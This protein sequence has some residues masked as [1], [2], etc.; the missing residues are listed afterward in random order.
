[1]RELEGL[2]YEEMA[3]AMGCS[4]GHDHVAAV[5]RAEEHAEAARSISSIRRRAPT[6][7][8]PDD[9]DEADVDGEPPRG[10]DEA[11]TIRA[12]AARRRRARRSKSRRR[13]E[14]PREGRRDR[15]SS[16]SSCAATSSSSA[17]AVPD[18]RFDAMWRE[19][20]KSRSAAPR[21]SQPRGAGFWRASPRWFD[22]Y[23]GH[24]ITGARQRGRGRRARARAARRRR[25]VARRRRPASTI[26]ST[27]VPRRI[28]PPRSS[29]STRRAAPARCS[30]S[31]DE[32]GQH[33][34]DLGDAR[35]YCGGHMSSPSLLAAS[36]V[37]IARLAARCV[38]RR[39]ADCSY[40]EIGATSGEEPAIDRRAQAAREE[41]EEAAV[42]VVEHVPASCRAARVR[43]TKLKAETLKLAQGGGDRCCCAIAPTSAL[44]LTVTIDDAD[45][46]RVA[47]RQA[48]RSTSATG[49]CRSAR[50]PRMTGTSSR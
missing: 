4:Q 42:L 29:R 43:S 47:R 37:A 38:R 18:A 30:I 11:A 22:R 40:L 19:I 25:A 31:N 49:S 27:H 26:R 32:D 6:T 24:M 7:L 8:D 28:A 17:D 39:Q 48:E 44:E 2:S 10:R 41:A 3:Q 1:M 21:R 12:D 15:A 5:S 14:A 34:R 33:D 20:D 45:G 35:G 36:L 46:K 50:T 16:A 23:R 9:A 13:S